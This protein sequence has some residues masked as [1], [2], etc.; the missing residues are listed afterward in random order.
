MQIILR[1]LHKYEAMLKLAISWNS[2]QEATSGVLLANVIDGI[3]RTGL[4][5]T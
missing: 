1:L 5:S 4:V 3:K 2:L